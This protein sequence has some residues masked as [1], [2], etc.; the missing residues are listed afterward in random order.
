MKSW[1]F[2]KAA[3]KWNPQSNTA[4]ALTGP[5]SRNQLAL[6]PK[7][8]HA[9]RFQLAVP[10]AACFSRLTPSGPRFSRGKR[11]A[12]LPLACTGFS[13]PHHRNSV[14]AGLVERAEDWKWNSARWYLCQQSVGVPLWW[15]G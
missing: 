5:A 10:S 1:R 14:R 2:T 13:R 8:L 11:T 6:G 3:R 7:L 4:R 9:G 15:P 12:P